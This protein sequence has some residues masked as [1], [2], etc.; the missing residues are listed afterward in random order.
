MVGANDL[1]I[2]FSANLPG[3]GKGLHLATAPTVVGVSLP[4]F[5]D[6]FQ[7]AAND[8]SDTIE[9]TGDYIFQEAMRDEKICVIESIVATVLQRFKDHRKKDPQRVFL[10]RNGCVEN[11]FDMVR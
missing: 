7:Y 5:R 11:N 6:I 2:G 1:Y 10:Y 8:V 9:F 3:S 4:S